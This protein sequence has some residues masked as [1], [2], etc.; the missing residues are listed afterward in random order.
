MDTGC[1]RS[2][3]RAH[4]NL[5]RSPRSWPLS[6]LLCVASWIS[7]GKPCGKPRSFDADIAETALKTLSGHRG[8][9]F[10]YRDLLNALAGSGVLRCGQQRLLGRVGTEGGCVQAL[11]RAAGA[12]KTCH[13]LHELTDLT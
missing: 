8:V 7:S 12:I 10:S 2:M 13:R 3:K 11:A 6:V 5:G 4:V 1:A 9:A